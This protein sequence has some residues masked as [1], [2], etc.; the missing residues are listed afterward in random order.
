[1]TDPTGTPFDL[2][3]LIRA[4]RDATGVFD[5]HVLSDVVVDAI[6]EADACEEVLRSVMPSRIREVLTQP[7]R[8]QSPA[9]AGERAANHSPRWQQ[10]R[11]HLNQRK[12]RLCAA[13][14]DVGD[15]KAEWKRF[16]QCTRA[17]VLVLVRKR[18]RDAA[19][20]AAKAA[21]YRA[22]HDAMVKAR[23]SSVEKLSARALA[24]IF[25]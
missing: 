22:T 14:V 15:E 25:G 6:I 12:A 17:E 16:G 10:V 8:Q 3:A 5:P 18:E 23:V 2:S 9:A 20:N 13:S 7:L 1:M 19:D 11:E 4:K 21:R 24:G